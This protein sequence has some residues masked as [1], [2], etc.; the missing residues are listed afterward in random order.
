MDGGTALRVDGFSG[1]RKLRILYAFGG[2][3][4]FIDPVFRSNEEM[5]S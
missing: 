5:R 1:M 4:P 3:V 2:H